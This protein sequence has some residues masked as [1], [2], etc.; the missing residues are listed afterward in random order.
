MSQQQF[1]PGKNDYNILNHMLSN[2]TKYNYLDKFN[3]HNKID[4]DYE[5]IVKEFNLCA[6][7]RS[8]QQYESGQQYGTFK[9]SLMP[10]DYQPSSYSQIKRCYP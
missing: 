3:E 9:L 1:I 2:M 4:Y 5:K 8:I 10:T 7:D 6:L